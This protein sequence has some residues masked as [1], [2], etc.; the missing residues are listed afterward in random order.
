MV[1]RMNARTV[2]VLMAM[3]ALAATGCEALIPLAISEASK[4]E[5]P[6]TSTSAPLSVEI[7]SA[8][9]SVEGRALRVD[10]LLASGVRI[11]SALH[12]EVR[13][14][15]DLSLSLDVS[16]AETSSD[17]PYTGEGGDPHRPPE[18]RP[19]PVDAGLGGLEPTLP[20]VPGASL[21]VCAAERCQRVEDFSVEIVETAEG[22][23]A[24]VEGQLP[25]GD[26]VSL[27][28]RYTE[29]S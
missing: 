9:G 1:K 11:D 19:V 24:L 18:G 20:G 28:L 10:S 2:T 15:A 8:N 26:Q 3:V 6:P 5:P 16:R 25:G 23:R 27:R 22:R 4:G 21:T 7:E 12:F 17:N 29:A 14:A 13:D